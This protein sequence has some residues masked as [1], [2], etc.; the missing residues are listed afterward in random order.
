VLLGDIIELRHSRIAEAFAD[1]AP[2][3]RELGTALGPERKVVIVAGNHDHHLAEAW[4]ERRTLVEHPA[5]LTLDSPVDWQVPEP[6][7]SVADW[8]APANVSARYP[9][10]WLREDV[11]ATHGHYLDR[12]TTVPL[13]ER[14]GVGLMG[15]VLR[16]PPGGPATPADYEA[17]LG[18]IYAWIHAVAQT[19]AHDI[20]DTKFDP[21]T[22]G[23]RVLTGSDGRRSLRGWGLVAGFP[24]LIG[25]MNRAGI[26][27]L[28]PELSGA[29]LR[30]AG[31]RAFA[32]VL[33]RLR[34]DAPY[35]I[36][37]HTHRAGPMPTDD[38]AEWQAPGGVRIINSG[39][40]V[41]QPDFLGP[42]PVTS[43]YRAG[44]AVRVEDEG[45]PELV[46]LLDGVTAPVPA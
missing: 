9:G 1:A 4:L 25:A 17:A 45:A 38:P 15:R 46:N 8:L 18:P 22:R 37:G 12:H 32:E 33:G 40:W 7:A 20:G 28:R 13:L 21:S 27:P 36:F 3:L 31:L 42:D 14:V 43:P 34:V 44:F 30:R 23:W 10:L 16:E 41:E 29:E 39:S 11:Y 26:G 2:M 24:L 6:L 35:T 5:S 19:G